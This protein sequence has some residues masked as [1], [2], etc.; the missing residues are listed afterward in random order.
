MQADF[1]SPSL[2]EPI[3]EPEPVAEPAPVHELAERVRVI[4]NVK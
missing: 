3:P 1:V 4:A 2:K